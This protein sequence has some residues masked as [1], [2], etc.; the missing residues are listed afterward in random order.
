NTGAA[1]E[2]AHGVAHLRLDERV[3]DDR[4][5]APRAVHGV[6]EVLDR[7]DARMADLLELLVGELSFQRLNETGRGLARG[8][9]DDV[10]FDGWM[11]R[12]DLIVADNVSAHGHRGSDDGQDRF[13]QPPARLRLPILRDLRWPRF[14]LR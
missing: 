6:L 1:A 10:Q 14:R 8:V 12:H 13:A 7:L 2:A 9:R 5:A 11:V 3:D 4:R